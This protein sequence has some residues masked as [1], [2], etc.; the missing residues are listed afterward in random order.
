MFTRYTCNMAT[1]HPGIIIDEQ[2]IANIFF[3]NETSFTA[4][5]FTI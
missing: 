2:P 4:N 5:M 3:G 1:I